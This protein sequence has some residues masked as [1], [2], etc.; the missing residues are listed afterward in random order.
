[1]RSE[2]GFQVRTLR[3]HL[4]AA[5]ILALVYLL[6]SV[7]RQ[8]KSRVIGDGRGRGDGQHRGLNDGGDRVSFM[9]RGRLG[10]SSRRGHRSDGADRGP[11]ADGDGG[12]GADVV[13]AG[14]TGASRADRVDGGGHGRGYGDLQ[15]TGRGGGRHGGATGGRV[16][17]GSDLSRG[18]SRRGGRHGLFGCGHGRGGRQ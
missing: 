4:L 9:V 5:R 6:G 2:V 8:V 12:I 7:R 16:R 14:G 13:G 1:M 10:G 17:G 11:A 18:D 15:Q 3:V